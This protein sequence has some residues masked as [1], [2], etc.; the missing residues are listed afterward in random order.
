MPIK[1]ELDCFDKT[2]L[3]ALNF[4]LNMHSEKHQSNWVILF[5]NGIFLTFGKKEDV[6]EGFLEC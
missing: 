3:N 2:A 4:H 1:L 6:C 5:Q